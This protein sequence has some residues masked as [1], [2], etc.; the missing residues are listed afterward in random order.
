MSLRWKI[1]FSLAAIALVATTSVGV[2]S[3]RSTAERLLAE[4]DRSIGQVGAQVV[5]GG[6]V[7]GVP[8][9]GE[10]GVY[11]VR[12]LTSNGSILASSFDHDIPVDDELD[13]VL[14]DRRASVRSTETVDGEHLRIHTIGVPGGAVQ[15][16]RSLDEVDRVLDDL[17]QRTALLVVVVSVAAATIGWVIAA[18]VA[19]PLRRLTRAAEDVGASGE[20][21]V[22][23]E[24][25][26]SDEVGR[27]AV[28]FREMLDA[29][30]R[31]RLAQQRL[32]DDAGHELRTPLTSLR[33][34][35]AVLRRHDDLTDETRASIL[36][37]LDD[38]ITELTELVDELVTVAG[39]DQPAEP[40][41]PIELERTVREA[42]ARVGRRRDREV[43]VAASD[44]ATVR[45]APAAVERAVTNLV[46]NACKF[47]ESGGPIEVVVQGGAVRVLD[48]GPG[49][50]DDAEKVFDRFYRAEAA[51]SLPG[52]GLGLA[53]VAGM[54]ERAGGSVFALDRHGG[55]AEV[56]F[57][58]PAIDPI[59]PND[60]V[61]GDDA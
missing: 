16:T 43:I 18:G 9:R 51:R 12:V 33:T 1:A 60:Q 58:L 49:V 37:D 6:R 39:G 25:H 14:G 31:S 24:A 27:L 45:A 34:N 28:A 50:G 41:R 38:E 40:T 47:D 10:L 59:T 36:A 7:A 22:E 44:P 4:V 2:V 55:G 32:V 56:G 53:I 5:L 52:S 21:D 3:Y 11:G 30:S 29:L 46:D 35:L 8:A 19:A 17:R 61:D 54:A 57:L 23:V 15:V 42:A 20:L 48:R 13:W 26:G